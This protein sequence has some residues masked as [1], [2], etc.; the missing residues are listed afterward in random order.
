V[1]ATLAG[2]ATPRLGLL[3]DYIND[4]KRSAQLGL[5]IFRLGGSAGYLWSASADDSGRGHLRFLIIDAS[6]LAPGKASK[7][8]PSAAPAPAAAAPAPA[9]AIEAEKP[10]GSLPPV[11][12]VATRPVTNVA[13][14]TAKL[15]IERVLAEPAKERSAVPKIAAPAVVAPDKDKPRVAALA[16][17]A[18][19]QRGYSISGRPSEAET[20]AVDAKEKSWS[21]GER[22]MFALAALAVLALAL[23]MRLQRK[24]LAQRQLRAAGLK[25]DLRARLGRTEVRDAPR[26]TDDGLAPAG[27]MAPAVPTVFGTLKAYISMACFL[28]VAASIYLA[29]QSPAAIKHFIAHLTTPK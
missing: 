29:S 24:D 13:T 6:V 14:K 17:E 4:V 22:I 5:P 20:P 3:V 26:H 21:L 1:V 27:A 11:A 10:T 28:T 16:S 15:Q 25:A 18:S 12:N 2:E 19:D 23:A 7:P 8:A 9:A